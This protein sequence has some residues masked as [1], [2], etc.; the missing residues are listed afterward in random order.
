[1][2]RWHRF[3]FGAAAG[4]VTTAANLLYTAFS[5]PLA[6]YFLPK[7]EFALWAVVVQI[8]GYLVLLDL[9]MSSAVSRFLADHKDSVNGGEYGSLIKTGRLV[10]GIQAA[11]LLFFAAVCAWVLPSFLEIHETHQAKFKILLAGNAFIQAVGLALRAETAP[12][13]AHQRI[14]ITQWVIS[15]SLLV[16]FA[17]MTTG[18]W[19][20]WG[21]YSYLFGSALGGVVSWV[22]GLWACHRLCLY[23]AK[24]SWGSFQK[25]LFLRMIAFG[26]DVFLMQLGALLCSGSQILLVTKFLGLETAATFAIATKTLTMGQQVIGRILESAAPGLTELFVRG[27]RERFTRRFYQMFS[28]SL[29]AATVLAVGLMG[30]NRNF[31]ALWTHHSVIWSSTGDLLISLILIATVFVRCSQGVFGMSADFSRVRWFALVEGFFF[32]TA[33]LLANEW[34][35][36][37]G[38]LIIAFGSQFFC[39]LLPSAAQAYRSFPFKSFWVLC[40]AWTLGLLFLGFCFYGHAG[41]AEDRNLFRLVYAACFSGMTFLFLFLGLRNQLLG[42]SN[43]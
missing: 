2:N 26:R 20:G 33:T 10:L 37:E 25:V 43:S 30:G 27:E 13:W 5:V 11:G 36:L 38:V 42:N 19:V 24:G 31:V 18:F 1:M 17:S 35:S 4:Y 41:I 6:L 21:I 29:F 28:V 39:S 40:P 16:S 34:L 7:E 15:F 23:P 8:C 3:F 12:L 32:I 14:D 9:G 22:L